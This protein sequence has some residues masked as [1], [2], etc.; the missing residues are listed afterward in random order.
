MGRMLHRMGMEMHRMERE[1]VLR[2]KW[3]KNQIQTWELRRWLYHLL[4][5]RPC[6]FAEILF[7]PYAHSCCRS[8]GNWRPFGGCT[9]GTSWPCSCYCLYTFCWYWYSPCPYI[10]SR[11]PFSFR[12]LD[13]CFDTFSCGSTGVSKNACRE[14]EPIHSAGQC[15]AIVTLHNSSATALLRGSFF[16]LPRF[17]LSRS[18]SAL[19]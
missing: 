8:P 2:Q 4:A 5:C 3:C 10:Y 17:V 9:R 13:T 15:A 14:S 18:S 12:R 11:H 6:T 16:E 1:R 7:W 19:F